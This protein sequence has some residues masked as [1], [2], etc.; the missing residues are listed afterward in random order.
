MKVHNTPNKR[1]RGVECWRLRVAQGHHGRWAGCTPDP[2]GGTGGPS[3]TVPA[4]A[5]SSPCH[6]AWP[7]HLTLGEQRPSLAVKV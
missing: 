4:S 5:P 3:H 2:L 6:A 1:V 7:P